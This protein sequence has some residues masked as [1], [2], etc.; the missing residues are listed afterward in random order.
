[1]AVNS[2]WQSP[3]VFGFAPLALLSLWPRRRGVGVPPSG[4]RTYIDS[5]TAKGV[6]SNV[7]EAPAEPAHRLTSNLI[8][9]S[10]WLFLTWWGLTHRIDRFWLPM[11][12]IVC[13]LA[14]IG[15]A[16]L[17]ERLERMFESGRARSAILFALAL[18][19]L[20]ILG[21]AYN[22]VLATSAQGR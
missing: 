4:G 1:M 3:L 17:V 22:L 12:P 2:A 15:G 5:V 13:A 10:A 18:S 9:Y 16:A 20:S 21:T 8:L 19:C 6:G 7:S 11:L 14:G